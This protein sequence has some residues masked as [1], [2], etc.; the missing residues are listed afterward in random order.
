MENELLRDFLKEMERTWE[1]KLNTGS[2]KDMQPSIRLFPC[3]VSL[4]YHAADITAFW[5]VGNNQP[6]NLFWF[7]GY[8]RVMAAE[9]I[10]VPMAAAGS[11]FG[12]NASTAST[13]IT[14]L[15]GGSCTNMACFQRFAVFHCGE[16][17]RTY[18]N[19]LNRNF[20]ADGPNQK[21]VTDISYIPTK[22]GTLYRSIIRDLFDLSIV[23]YK[24]STRQSIK[25]EKEEVTAEL[26]LHSDQGFP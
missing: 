18:A 13:T 8:K 6:G 10:C 11:S 14:R 26:Q 20:H 25:V 2:Y 24:T 19:L 7:K 4:M 16:E 5:N 15:S 17:T 1:H 12:S 9:N 3:V 21:R 23:A 22:Q